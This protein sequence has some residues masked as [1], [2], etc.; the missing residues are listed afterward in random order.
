MKE[1]EKFREVMEHQAPSQFK[2]KL[3]LESKLKK[4]WLDYFAKRRVNIYR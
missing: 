4:V 1:E 2:N 3:V